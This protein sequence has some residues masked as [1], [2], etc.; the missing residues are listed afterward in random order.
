MQRSAYAQN[1]SAFIF[2]DTDLFS[3]LGYYRLYG[4]GTVEDINDCETAACETQSSLYIVM[5]SNIRFTP[6]P[7]RYGVTKRESDDQF[8]IDIL[9]EYD[10]KYHVVQATNQ[11]AQEAEVQQV[12]EKF[13]LDQNPVFGFERV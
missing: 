6:D 2:Q 10:L 4:G 9:E 1:H 12:I 11:H 13:F 5:N 3:T 7:L 8:W